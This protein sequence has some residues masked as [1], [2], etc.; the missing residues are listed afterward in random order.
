MKEG[1]AI[2]EPSPPPPPP[3]LHRRIFEGLRVIG[4]KK[5]LEE[6]YGVRFFPPNLSIYKWP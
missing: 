1:I 5:S 4:K 6:I 3:S 2:S